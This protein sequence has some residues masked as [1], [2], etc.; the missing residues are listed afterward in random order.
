MIMCK[1]IRPFILFL[2]I[3]A[4]CCT[5][6]SAQS[7]AVDVKYNSNIPDEEN[8]LIFYKPGQLL[9]ISDFTANPV[10]GN[11]VVAMTSSG[12]D[13]KASYI[14]KDGKSTLI[15]SV[16]CSFDKQQSWM[17]ATGK[18]PYILS[19]EQIH[20]DISYIAAKAFIFKLKAASFTQQNHNSLIQSIYQEVSDNL[21]KMQQQYDNE[22]NNGQLKDKQ[23]LWSKKVKALVAKNE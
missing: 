2:C 22:T 14:L 1:Q 16:F 7:F 18:T 17:K 10:A 12:F 11:D 15:I 19:H 23:A 8:K 6:S 3:S 13:S 4:C 9:S 20:F 5:V 21:E